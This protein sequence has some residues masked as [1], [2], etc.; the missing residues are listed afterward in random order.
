MPVLEK[1]LTQYSIKKLICRSKFIT[2]NEIINKA[3]GIRNILYCLRY[4]VE[5]LF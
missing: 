4:R 3:L 5:E 1:S 2:Y